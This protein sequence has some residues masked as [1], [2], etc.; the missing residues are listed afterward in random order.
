[1]RVL[2]VG[3]LVGPLGSCTPPNA[4]YTWGRNRIDKVNFPNLNLEFPDVII[5]RA[6]QSR[7]SGP[8]RIK[9]SSFGTY[10]THIVAA[11]GALPEHNP[12]NNTLA[13]IPSMTTG[14]THAGRC[15]CLRLIPK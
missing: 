7:G 11:S 9:T 10:L 2:V 14:S 3:C 6:L 13:F 12:S 8:V 1:M 5:F 15:K 4:C